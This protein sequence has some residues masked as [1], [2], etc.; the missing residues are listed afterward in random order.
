[1][2]WV[3]DDNLNIILIEGG[4]DYLNDF[5]ELGR[6]EGNKKTFEKYCIIV[7]IFLDEY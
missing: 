4:E 3:V 1:M 7:S 2:H 6:T 5:C